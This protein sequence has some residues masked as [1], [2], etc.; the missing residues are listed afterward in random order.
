MKMTNFQIIFTGI[1]LVFIVGGVIA[2]S[3]YTAQTN[4]IGAVRIWGT[5]DQT[6]MTQL[7]QGLNLQ[8]RS[9]QEVVYEQKPAE[10]YV[11][12][13]INAM[14][15]GSGPDVIMI[16]QGQLVNFSNK[17]L[18]IPYSAVSQSEFISSYIEESQLFLTQSGSLALPFLINPLVMY[19]NRDLFTSAGIPTPPVYWKELLTEA[20]R[21]TTLDKTNNI[22]Q[23]AIAM[24]SW[25]NV[26]YAKA[27]FSTL[28]MQAG[29]PIVYYDGNGKLTSS[30]GKNI[31]NAQENPSTS[32]LQ[33]YTEFANPSKITYSWNRSL[34]KSADAFTAGKL[35][36]YLGFAS[37]NAQL[38]ARNP[39]VRYGVAVMPQLEGSSRHVTFGQ[40]TGLAIP[41]TAANPKGALVIIQK[42]TNQIGV[43]AAAQAFSLPPVRTDI[44]VDASANAAADVFYQ[45]AL[46]ARG[47]LDPDPSL[48]DGIFGAMVDAVVSNRSLPDGAVQDASQALQ[49]LF[50]S[51]TR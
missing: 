10:T 11:D 22:S 49:A 1:F 47:W 19:W 13:V 23:S 9:F 14:A 31:Q 35:A 50:G 21:L 26:V 7:I 6:A 8:D 28:A 5:V 16:S 48:T 36:I 33:F 38:A 3:L 2:F 44:A 20:G 30:F 37:D 17:L 43:T 45:S 27:I 34:P 12:D 29:D 41:R 15:S 42:L 32:A 40:L 46:I 39:N 4:S 51:S 24:G 18:T 25:S